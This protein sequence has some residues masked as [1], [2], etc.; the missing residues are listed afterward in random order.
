MQKRNWMQ[1]L[2]D[3]ADLPAEP[4]PGVPVVEVAG[5]NRVLIERHAGVT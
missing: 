4:L 5:E 2:A 1:M 3:G